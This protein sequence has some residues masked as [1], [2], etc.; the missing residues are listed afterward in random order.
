MKNFC[1]WMQSSG[2][3]FRYFDVFD[4][5]EKFGIL[6]GNKVMEWRQPLVQRSSVRTAVMSDYEPRLEAFLRT[7]I[8]IC[9]G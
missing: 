4:R 5:I 1:S 7:G 6:E 8:R 9:R 2:P 3:V